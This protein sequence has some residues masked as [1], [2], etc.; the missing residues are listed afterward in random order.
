MDVRLAVTSKRDH[1][2]FDPAPL[3]DVVIR[4][5]LDAGRL[6]GSARNRQPWRFFVATE[7][8]ARSRI[9]PLV[10]VPRMIMAAPLVVGIAVDGAGSAMSGFDGGRAAQQMMLAA[11]G[12]GIASCPNGIARPGEARAVF[13]LDDG[14]QVVAIVAFG[15]PAAPRDPARR[16]PEEWSA[17]ARRRPLEAFVV[18]V[19]A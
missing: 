19:P 11:W 6:T 16:S 9:A 10:Y 18:E 14:E 17:R 8:V 2:D 13:G 7:P 12:E 4:R 3:D 15:A 1:R 5:I